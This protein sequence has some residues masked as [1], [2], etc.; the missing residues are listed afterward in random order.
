MTVVVF[1]EHF[2]KHDTLYIHQL[3]K[4]LFWMI[5]SIMKYKNKVADSFNISIQG[6][7]STKTI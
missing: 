6:Y 2:N 7:G 1:N 3:R 4:E 5:L